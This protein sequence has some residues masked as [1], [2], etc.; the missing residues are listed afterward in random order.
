M[1]YFGVLDTVLA[2]YV[3]VFSLTMTFG[4]EPSVDHISICIHICTL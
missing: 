2:A 3:F 4:T 1:I